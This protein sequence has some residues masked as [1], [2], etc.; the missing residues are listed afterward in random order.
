MARRDLS[1]RQSDVTRAIR[2][3]VA[4]GLSVARVM[5]DK[6]GAIVVIAGEPGKPETADRNEWDDDQ[7]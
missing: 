3:V 4:A 2:A 1:F 5:V 6:T 7:G